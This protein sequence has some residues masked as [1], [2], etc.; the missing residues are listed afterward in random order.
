MIQ[1]ES[2]HSFE[3]HYFSSYYDM[4]SIYTVPEN[5]Y[6][7]IEF[8]QKL[9]NKPCELPSSPC[10]ITDTDTL[11]VLL[12]NYLFIGDFRDEYRWIEDLSGNKHTIQVCTYVIT[13]DDFE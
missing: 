4:D 12:D 10:S 7:D 11:V 6:V 13:D 1:N 8:T 9:G 5:S 3:V 2:S